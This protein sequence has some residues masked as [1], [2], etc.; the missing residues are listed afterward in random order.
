MR[1][2][3][4]GGEIH[5]ERNYPSGGFWTGQSRKGSLRHDNNVEERSLCHRCVNAT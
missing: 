1:A 2:A 5:E 4:L 3:A